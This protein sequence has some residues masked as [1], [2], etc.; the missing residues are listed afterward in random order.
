[1]AA[2][3]WEDWERGAGC[4]VAGCMALA[5]GWLDGTPYCFA[6]A[7]LMLERMAAIELARSLRETLPPIEHR[8]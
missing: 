7:E 1:V 4:E 2:P 8:R 3:N 5:D 6:C